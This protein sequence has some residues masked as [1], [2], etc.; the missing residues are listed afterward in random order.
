[1]IRWPSIALGV[2]VLVGI[3]LAGCGSSSNSDAT[4]PPFSC[5]PS[6]PEEGSVASLNANPGTDDELVPGEPDRLLICR[7]WGLGRSERLAV[8]RQFREPSKVRE[9]AADLDNLEPWPEGEYSCEEDDGART[10]ALFGY[11]EEAP[12]V[13]EISLTGCPS[14]LNGKTHS[15]DPVPL[16]QNLLETGLPYPR[17]AR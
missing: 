5:P 3:V 1:M 9:Y 4:T 10:L 17:S 13:V 7:Y 6:S 14:A 8:K 16:I 15:Y 12:A 11:P 2:V